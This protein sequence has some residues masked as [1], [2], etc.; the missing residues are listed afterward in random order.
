MM[1][2]W[3]LVATASMVSMAGMLGCETPTSVEVAEVECAGRAPLRRLNRLEY[4]NTVRDLLGVEGS[5]AAFPADPVI[6]GFDDQVEGQSMSPL[7]AEHVMVG[8]EQLA[9]EALANLDALL[10]CDPGASVETETLCAAAFI[11]EFGLRAYR[12]PLDDGQRTSL[13][14]TY[15]RGRELE[16][17]FAAGLRWVI[18]RMLQS[19]QFLYRIELEGAQVEDLHGQAIVALD[20]WELASRLSYLLWRSMPDERLFE[21]AAAG[22]LGDRDTLAAEAAR[23]LEDPRADATLLDFHRQWLDLRRLDQALKSSALYPEFTPALVSS[24]RTS[25][26]RFVEHA[27]NEG[28]G[29]LGELL[30]ADYAFVDSRLATLYGVPHSGAPGFERVDLDPQQRRGLLTHAS[31]L[32]GLAGAE[33][34]SPV[35]RGRFVRERLLCGELSPPP[36][37]LDTELPPLEPGATTRERFEQHTSDPTCAGCHVLMDPIGFGFEHYDAIGRFRSDQDGQAIDASGTVVGLGAAGDVA[38][39]GAIELATVLAEAPAVEACYA[40]QWFRYGLGRRE[41]PEVDAC[42]LTTLEDSLRDS[43]G[44]VRALLLAL[45]VS[46]AFLVRTTEGLAP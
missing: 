7:L 4:D 10:P 23:M 42:T 17:E 18:E 35:S 8:A 38:F 37:G 29:T 6:D 5:A 45:V 26:D 12:R 13:M 16:G 24:M 1:Q 11:D 32:A 21:L 44:D 25:T 2:R 27:L 3:I 30:G 43:G 46:D 22:T 33:E 36:P 14:T 34:S 15:A 19:P 20:D 41:D 31:V 28:E 39:D 40:R 9:S